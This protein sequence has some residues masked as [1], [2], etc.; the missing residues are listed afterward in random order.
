MKSPSFKLT[1]PVVAVKFLI[2]IVPLLLIYRPF[3]LLR[4]TSI[5]SLLNASKYPS[6][7]ERLEPL[8]WRITKL[9]AWLGAKFGLAF[10]NPPRWL[11]PILSALFIICP[12]SSILYSLNSFILIPF[13]LGVEMF[14]IDTPFADSSSFVL[15]FELGSTTKLAANISY[16]ILNLI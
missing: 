8:T 12:F 6:I 15:W 14:T 5:L 11:L 16:Y 13:L 7:W 1:L 2:L 10:I 4:I 9:A 3:S